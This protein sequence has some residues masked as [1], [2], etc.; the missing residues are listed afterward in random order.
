MSFWDTIVGKGLKGA[1][2]GFAAGGPIGAAIGA[3]DQ[4]TGG[5]IGNWLNN[6]A[7]DIG[8]ATGLADDMVQRTPLDYNQLA[9]VASVPGFSGIQE[10][11]QGFNNQLYNAA[12]DMQKRGGPAWDLGNANGARM[13]QQQVRGQQDALSQMLMNQAMGNGPSMAQM[14][15]KQATDRNM[16]QALGLAAAGARGGRGAGA[17]YHL[18]NQRAQIGQQM[19]ADSGLLRMNE[20]L[21]ARQLASQHQAQMRGQDLG[22]RGQDIG[23][24]QAQVGAQLQQRGLNDAMTQS[25]WG[26]LGAGL[27]REGNLAQGQAGLN[28]QQAGNQMQGNLAWDTLRQKEKWSTEMN[29][30]G[31]IKTAADVGMK[32]AGVG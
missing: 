28:V 27:G 12:S 2:V 19:A 25:A 31:L 26:N 23:L 9:Q 30:L 17:A 1:G 8:Q 11:N 13:Q 6:A 21:Q 15:L 3:V 18:G 20:M 7:T 4:N 22:L 5:H 32:A 29:R 10:R 16:A 24:A 14:Q